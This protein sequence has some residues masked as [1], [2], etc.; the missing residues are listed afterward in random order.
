M[1]GF[2]V[3]D[4]SYG[5]LS[6]GY[7]K[8]RDIWGII[9][10]YITFFA[11]FALFF[12]LLNH[13]DVLVLLVQY[14]CKVTKTLF[15]SVS[16][17]YLVLSLYSFFGGIICYLFLFFLF[18]SFLFFHSSLY[19]MATQTR[20][21]FTLPQTFVLLK[22][23]SISWLFFVFFF[24]SSGDWLCV[25]VLPSPWWHLKGLIQYELG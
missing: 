25:I 20:H 9:V 14:S 5:F 16:L 2:S 22:L 15:S 1:N 11:T 13:M 3:S 10:V 23:I 12:L 17:Y 18:F 4:K 24:L 19:K 21:A 8:K 7:V 6:T